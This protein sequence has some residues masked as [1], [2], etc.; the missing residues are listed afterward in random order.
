MNGVSDAFWRLKRVLLISKQRG[1]LRFWVPKWKGS[2][3]LVSRDVAF[4]EGQRVGGLRSI[5]G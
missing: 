4:L 1:V 3:C 2:S 5:G